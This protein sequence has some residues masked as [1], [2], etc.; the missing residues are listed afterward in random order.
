MLWPERAPVGPAIA[1]L[2]GIA[3]RR[4]LARA[5]DRTMPSFASPDARAFV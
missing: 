2:F 5:T 4:S 3:A 1:Q